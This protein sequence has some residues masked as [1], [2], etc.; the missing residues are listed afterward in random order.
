MP[1]SK[2]P[3]ER[4]KRDYL[5]FLQHTLGRHGASL[6]AVAAALARF[7]R[8]TRH[9]DFKTFH[10]EQAKGFKEHLAHSV[11]E[12][13]GAPL[14]AATIASTLATLRN[15]FRWLADRPGYRSKLSRSDA[16][17]FTPPTALT[18]V[19]AAKREKPCP[20]VDQ[21]RTVLARMPAETDIEKRDRALIAFTLL[22]GARD[23]AI[24][25]V[26]LRHVDIAA[27][28]FDQDARDLATK[29][30]KTFSTTFFPVGEDV[31]K[32]LIDWVTF[33]RVERHWRD[34]D[35]LFPATE[36]GISADGRFAPFGLSRQHWTTATPIRTVFRT[37]F[38]AAGLPYANPHSLR[39]T[40]VRLAYDMDLTM[41]ETKAWSQNL[42]HA[43]VLTTLTSY[44]ELPT[45]RKS[46][47]MRGL[48]ERGTG[49]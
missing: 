42:G 23:G 25:G 13:T 24:V 10:I 1:K 30:S 4:I 2:T 26:K 47:I 33:L 27:S 31:R 39:N 32:I 29:G 28:R 36:I 41:E 20:T 7:E 45:H 6:E 3:N 15:F 40:L 35:P 17:Y 21:V 49:G 16:E 14:A 43:D 9:R 48:A 12:R 11:N 8:Y 5:D 38:E 22:T 34:A 18:R 37:A 46:D 19:A 44:G